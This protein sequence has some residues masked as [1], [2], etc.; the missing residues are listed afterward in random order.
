MKEEEE[1][2]MWI[3]RS[4][5]LYTLLLLLPLPLPEVMYNEIVMGS[6]WES[7]WLMAS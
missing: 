7:F 4:T 5:T 1:V 6:D 3:N 2:T